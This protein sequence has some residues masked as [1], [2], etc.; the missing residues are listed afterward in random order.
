MFLTKYAS[1]MEKLAF[2]VAKVI[3]GHQKKKEAKCN[4]KQL[5]LMA[6]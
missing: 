2:K 6:S 3:Q 4:S 1:F 5:S